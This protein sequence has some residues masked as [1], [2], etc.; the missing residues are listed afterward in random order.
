MLAEEVK[1]IRGNDSQLAQRPDFA[2][3]VNRARAE[4]AEADQDM[5]SSQYNVVNRLTP[6]VST[7]G[8]TAAAL[9]V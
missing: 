7:I 6:D 8:S 1:F 9:A 4:M 5:S 3:G 2:D